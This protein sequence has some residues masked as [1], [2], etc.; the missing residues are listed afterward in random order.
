MENV[1]VNRFKHQHI[2]KGKDD[3]YALR[4]NLVTV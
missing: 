4:I 1:K 2:T 3:F